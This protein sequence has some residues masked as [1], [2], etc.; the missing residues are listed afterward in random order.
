MSCILAIQ[1]QN[2]I[3]EVNSSNEIHIRENKVELFCILE[4][5][6]IVIVYDLQLS[7]PEG[8]MD[9]PGFCYPCTASAT[10]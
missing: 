3:C 2:V 4:K 6:N 7:L 1:Y 5:C 8:D 10:K 9:K